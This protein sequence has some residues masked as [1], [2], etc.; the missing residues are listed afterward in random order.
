MGN[1]SGISVREGDVKKP[2]I[3]SCGS[4]VFFAKGKSNTFL[5]YVTGKKALKEKTKRQVRNKSSACLFHMQSASCLIHRILT[6]DAA[7]VS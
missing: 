2:Q 7:C 1:S 5:I 6:C 4:I 3:A